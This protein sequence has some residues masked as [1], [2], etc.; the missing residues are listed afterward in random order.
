MVFKDGKEFKEAIYKYSA[1]IKRELKIIRNEP[2]RIRVKCKAVAK[3]PWQI[4]GSYSKQARGIQIKSFKEEHNCPLS[5]TDKMVTVKLI[6]TKYEKAIKDNPKM[7]LKDLK[8]RVK[9]DMDAEVNLSGCKR[10]KKMVHEKLAGNY[11][12]EYALLRAYGNELLE[13]NPGSTV[14]ISVDRVTPE[15]PP[16]FKRI[17]M[18]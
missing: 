10:A 16:H 6:A 18:S 12:E 7:S 11:E 15:S 9:D 5:F 3:C 13:K 2:K 8:E 1:F 14:I 17:Y 4:Y